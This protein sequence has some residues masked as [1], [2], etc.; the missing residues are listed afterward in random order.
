MA[1]GFDLGFKHMRLFSTSA[2]IVCLGLLACPLPPASAEEPPV[3][4]KVGMVSDTASFNDAGFNHSCKAGLERAMREFKVEGCFRES[5]KREDY[6]TNLNALVDAR[7]GLII[8][9]GSMMHEAMAKVADENPD[10]KFALVDSVF[11]PPMPNVESITFSVEEAAFPVGFLAAA[12]A[13]YKDPQNARVGFVGG[14][15]IDAVRQFVVPYQAGVAFFNRKYD[16]NVRVFGDFLD[17]FEDRKK[18][19]AMGETLIAEGVDVIFGVGGQ[20]GAGALVAAKEHGK[21][22]I[23]VDVDQYETLPE[24]RDCLLTSCLKRMDNAVFAVIQNV[25]AGQFREASNMVGTLARGQVGLA[26][27]HDLDKQIPD[28]IRK[29]LETIQ[30]AIQGGKI[31]TGWPPSYV[32][33]W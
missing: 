10:V 7:C 5:R 15:K 30:L 8:G 1:A 25:L 19:K 13:N 14:M 29:D 2:L 26:P 11:Y 6:E 3:R 24:V 20:T 16:K 27:F 18:G 21:W 23:G 31:A 28:Q 33:P 12:W 9:V 17:T 32:I 4:L 22:G